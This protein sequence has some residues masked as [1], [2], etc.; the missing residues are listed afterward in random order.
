MKTIQ[1]IVATDGST[2]LETRGFQG[3][4]CREASRFLERA[5]GI[6][7]SETLTPEFHQTAKN[8]NTTSQR[9]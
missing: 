6:T 2:R 8:Q 5:L 9:P 7:Q 1:I 4:D 3:A